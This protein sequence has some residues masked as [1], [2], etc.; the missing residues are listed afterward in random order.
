VHDLLEQEVK[1]VVYDPLALEGAKASLGNQVSYA[2]TVQECVEVASVCVVANRD[3]E[4][5]L[6]IE[7]YQGNK[8]KFVLDCWRMLDRTRLSANIRYLA[9]GQASFN[10]NRDRQAA[11]DLETHFSMRTA[12]N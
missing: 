5:K 2:A 10:L 4:F 7:E 9:W 11:A 12:V 3:P 6:A 8:P 1:V